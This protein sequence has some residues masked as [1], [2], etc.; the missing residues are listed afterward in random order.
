MCKHKPQLI[1]AVCQ[2]RVEC[3]KLSAKL[4]SPVTI[5]APVST[6][7]DFN[8]P[9]DAADNP[10]CEFHYGGITTSGSMSTCAEQIRLRG[11]VRKPHRVRCNKL[12]TV[13]N[14]K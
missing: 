6:A 4:N 13:N 5:L 10:D 2:A 12:A 14:L 7:K 11:N 3:A 8:A 1:D 9:M